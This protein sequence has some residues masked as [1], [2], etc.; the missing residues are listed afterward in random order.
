MRDW[1]A[2][3]D[4]SRAVGLGADHPRQPRGA[5]GSVVLAKTLPVRRD[6]AGVANGKQ[7]VIGRVSQ[8]IDDLECSRLLEIKPVGIDGV[9]QRY[10]VSA[11]EVAHSVE[12]GVEGALER[13]Y[14]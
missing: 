3:H 9:H 8:D 13:H 14:L 10:R 4:R 1:M 7:Q 11:R 2:G 6:I 5:T 12:R